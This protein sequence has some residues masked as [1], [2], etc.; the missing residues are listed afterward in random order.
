MYTSLTEN[1]LLVRFLYLNLCNASV[2]IR[3]FRNH[4]HTKER[5]K[6]NDPLSTNGLKSIIER[7]QGAGSVKAQLG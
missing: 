4:T 2:A 1:G 3:V 7:F 6:G 5:R